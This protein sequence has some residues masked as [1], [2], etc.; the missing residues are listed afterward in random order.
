[1]RDALAHIGGL[2]PNEHEGPI[3]ALAF[4]PDGRWLVTGSGDATARV[5][6]MNLKKLVEL[7]C[8]TVGCNFTRAEWAQYF[9][10][11]P[12]RKTCEQWEEGK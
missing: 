11:E 8:K 3:S 12:Y 9:G 1:M 4:S 2:P 7:A 5:W 10:E 6:D